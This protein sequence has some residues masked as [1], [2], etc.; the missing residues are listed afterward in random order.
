MVESFM[1]KPLTLPGENYGSTTLDIEM[2]ICHGKDETSSHNLSLVAKLVPPFE[3][4]QKVFDSP[5]T[6]CK[7]IT[8]Y[9]SLKLEYEKLQTE[10][11]IP[12][13]KF[14]VFSKCY[15]ARMTMLE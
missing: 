4:L 15:G 12:K 3:F 10:M 6:F 9:T 8:C 11:C 1:S 7:E 13:D 2:T 14:D 5:I